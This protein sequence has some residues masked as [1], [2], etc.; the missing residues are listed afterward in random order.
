MGGDPI[1]TLEKINLNVSA[2]SLASCKTRTLTK[3]GGNIYVLGNKCSFCV[4]MFYLPRQYD[5]RKDFVH[6]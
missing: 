4:G 2:K 5:F 6:L 3:N 1:R